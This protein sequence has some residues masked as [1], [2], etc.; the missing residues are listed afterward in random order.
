MTSR[1][2]RRVTAGMT[3]G[4]AAVA[5][6]PPLIGRGPAQRL[7]HRELARSIY[8]PSWWER[9]L[10]AI[11][12]W[13]NSTLGSLGPQHAGWWTLIVLIVVAL[14]VVAGVLAWIGPARRSRRQR[15][16]AVLTGTPLSA[17]D[18]RRAA[19][20]LAAEGDYGGAIVESVRALAVD[21]EARGILA[22]RPG[23]TASELADEAATALRGGAAPLGAA[24]RP[25][26][27]GL[28]TYGLGTPGPG[29]AEPGTP[30]VGTP[31]LGTLGR[32][33]GPPG[34]PATA[35]APGT[36]AALR[37]AARLFDDVRYGGRAGTR[38]GFE[39]VRDLD[40]TIAVARAPEVTSTGAEPAV[41]GAGSRGTGATP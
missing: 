15:A 36:A 39:R 8:R 31:G 6:A 22:P 30:G 2:T 9:L 23:R 13:L 17:A 7:A 10:R 32:P 21:L 4:M 19:Q 35:S 5:G 34:P 16:A 41:A 40:A 37:E 29:T 18:H 11:N 25:G 28:A 12:R 3:A 14:L 38:E 26:T 33:A 24:P 1:T 20:R 27:P